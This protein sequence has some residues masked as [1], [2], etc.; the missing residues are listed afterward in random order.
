[1][2]CAARETPKNP[3]GRDTRLL[4]LLRVLTERGSENPCI[5]AYGQVARRTSET[6]V[7]APFSSS[8]T[9]PFASVLLRSVE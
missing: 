8:D 5:P 6:A 4:R 2:C 9:G 7:H 3:S 1:M